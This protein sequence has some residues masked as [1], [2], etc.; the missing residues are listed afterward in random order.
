MLK[1][2]AEVEFVARAVRFLTDP[3]SQSPVPLEL[4]AGLVAERAAL[5]GIL[6]G[7]LESDPAGG[8]VI[9]AGSGVILLLKTFA[10]AVVA[11]GRLIRGTSTPITHIWEND[12]FPAIVNHPVHYDATGNVHP[13]QAIFDNVGEAWETAIAAVFAA[14]GADQAL[15]FRARYFSPFLG[16]GCGLMYRRRLFRRVSY[17]NLLFALCVDAI[18]SR[19]FRVPQQTNRALLFITPTARAAEVVALAGVRPVVRCR[20]FFIGA[21]AVVVVLQRACATSSRAALATVSVPEPDGSGDTV[22]AGG[23]KDA[24]HSRRVVAAVR[25]AL[26]LSRT[27][28]VACKGDAVYTYIREND[29]GCLSY[30]R[31]PFVDIF[32]LA[33][34]LVDSLLT[35]LRQLPAVQQSASD[36]AHVHES[37]F[38]ATHEQFAGLLVH[39]T[40]HAGGWTPQLVRALWRMFVRYAMLVAMRQALRR[41]SGDGATNPFGSSASFRLVI[42]IIG[43]TGSG[44]A[45]QRSAGPASTST[46]CTGLAASSPQLLCIGSGSEAEADDFSAF[47]ADWHTLM[48]AP[49]V[50]QALVARAIASSISGDGDDGN[51]EMVKAPEHWNNEDVG[52]DASEPLQSALGAVGSSL[53]VEEAEEGGLVNPT[54][55]GVSESEDAHTCA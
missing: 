21:A 9:G 28:V 48:S 17:V 26:L 41:G 36:L 3:D 11:A 19:L 30:P 1:D 12:V 2:F 27:E 53:Q 8:G 35:R 10:E 54:E 5:F 47:D 6:K 34:R 44:A 50:E 42:N 15:A 14:A 32:A 40:S 46:A 52:D 7:A 29:R 39:L 13:E 45:S 43:A 4:H 25:Q 37:V 24:E 31:H 23:G 33:L 22:M 49:G 38:T 16:S 51:A 18:S 20:N 55:D